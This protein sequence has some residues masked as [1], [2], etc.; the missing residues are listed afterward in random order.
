MNKQILRTLTIGLV[1]LI[2]GQGSVFAQ[3]SSRLLDRMQSRF[4]TIRTLSADFSQT[5]NSPFHGTQSLDGNLVMRGNQYRVETPQQTLVTDGRTTWVH[6]RQENQVLV[7]QYQKDET[8]FSVNDFFFNFNDQ[9]RVRRIAT[10]T[11]D[12][13]RHFRMHLLPRQTDAFFKE[14]TVWLRDRDTMISRVELLD[15]NDTRMTFNLRNVVI[16]PPVAV[17]AF[18]FTP[19]RGAEVVDLR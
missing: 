15:V 17:N 19:P 6:N 16:N 9:F 2:A 13:Q 5:V 14:A 4:S 10:V 3:S 8:T 11:M 12:G 1:V 18:T 7:N